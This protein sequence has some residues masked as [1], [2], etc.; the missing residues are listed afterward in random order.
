MARRCP[1]GARDAGMLAWMHPIWKLRPTRT[2]GWRGIPRFWGRQSPG[3]DDGAE[4]S[5]GTCQ[6]P[7]HCHGNSAGNELHATVVCDRRPRRQ[8]QR[9]PRRGRVLR[10]SPLAFASESRGLS[11]HVDVI[12]AQGYFARET[13][14]SQ[15]MPE[16]SGR[17]V[18][19]RD[20]GP[21]GNDGEQEKNFACRC[22]QRHVYRT[23]G[24]RPVLSAERSARGT[25]P[26]QLTR[27][28]GRPQRRNMTT[29]YEQGQARN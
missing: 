24:K 10:N 11:V 14:H 3:L 5:C 17:A 7:F 26:R 4:N 16:S 28:D 20:S 9:L 13:A 12:G 29:S 25:T 22:P 19:M 2:P 23:V 6:R 21:S 18:S 15:S 8:V 1:G 27:S